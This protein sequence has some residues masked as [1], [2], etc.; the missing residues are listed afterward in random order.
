MKVLLAG[1]S[2]ALGRHLV[3][4][5]QSARH[6]PILLCRDRARVTAPPSVQV[7]LAN[8]TV[9]ESLEGACQ[10]VD[11]V[12]SCA[13]APL[14][15]NFSQPA[16]FHDIDYLGNANLLA[17]ARRTGFPATALHPGHIV[18]PGWAP[19]NPAGLTRIFCVR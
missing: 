19:L 6:D 12:I 1:A 4:L 2:G 14:R 8:L 5:L 3:P 7:R 17:E 9:P 15:L 10:G 13:G 16:A 18:G 11:T